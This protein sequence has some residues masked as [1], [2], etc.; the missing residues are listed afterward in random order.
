M[1]QAGLGCLSSHVAAKTPTENKSLA[2][3]MSDDDSLFPAGGPVTVVQ[4]SNLDQLRGEENLVLYFSPMCGHCHEFAKTYTAFAQLLKSK[5]PSVRCYAEDRSADT[6]EQ[7]AAYKASHPGFEVPDFVPK[8]CLYGRRK[9][10]PFQRMWSDEDGA[11]SAES[12]AAF[13]LNHFTTLK[14]DERRELAR[15]F[16]GLQQKPL[17]GGSMRGWGQEVSD[18]DS[19]SGSDS[20]SDSDLYGGAKHKRGKRSAAKRSPAKRSPAKRA[21]SKWARAL[22]AAHKVLK[23]KGKIS[24]AV[25]FCK[26]DPPGSPGRMWYDEAKRHLR[27]M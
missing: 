16:K 9:G 8:I 19:D 20:D 17:S 6:R 10:A 5:V 22:A 18:S 1:G 7:V 12:L 25:R 14:P 24:G 3:S 21:P 23:A 11:K 27:A 15:P 13:V 4:L 2:C 26:S